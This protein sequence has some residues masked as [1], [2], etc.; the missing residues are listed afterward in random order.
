[1]D[2][3]PLSFHSFSPFSNSGKTPLEIN[4]PSSSNMCTWSKHKLTCIP[5]SPIPPCYFLS[6]FGN[7]PFT[8]FPFE[9]LSSS[10]NTLFHEGSVLCLASLA[11]LGEHIGGILVGCFYYV[12]VFFHSFSMRVLFFSRKN[13]LLNFKEW[14]FSFGTSEIK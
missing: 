14:S 4:F 9:T 1:M 3:S 6:S 11:W 2:L 10:L 7:Y 8:H 5:F 12:L 13:Y